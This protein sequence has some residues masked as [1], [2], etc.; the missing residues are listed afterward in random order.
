MSFGESV[1]SAGVGTKIH[2]VRGTRAS[3]KDLLDVA[4]DPPGF[5]TGVVDPM[6][7]SRDVPV[8]LTLQL[9]RR[10]SLSVI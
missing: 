2:L 10:E 4:V 7:S 5:N 6:Y 9:T 8:N 1:F 3:W